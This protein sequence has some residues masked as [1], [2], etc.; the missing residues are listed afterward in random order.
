MA[1]RRAPTERKSPGTGTGKA[2]GASCSCR[3]GTSSTRGLSGTRSPPSNRTPPSSLRPTRGRR[4]RSAGARLR[5][6]LHAADAPPCSRP[7]I[8]HAALV[9]A[10][11]GVNAALLLI[12]NDPKRFDRLAVVAPYMQLEDEPEPPDPEWL[13]DLR[14]DWP[15]FIVPFMHRGLHGAGLGRLIAE[16]IAIGLEA[17]P[18]VAVIQELELDWNGRPVCSGGSPAQRSS[19]TARPTSRSPPRLPRASSQPCRTHS[20]S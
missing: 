3:R 8:E 4:Q 15:G 17:T 1:W 16:M 9:T 11:R 12:A 5:L 20:W 7:G 10:S 6:S 18:E 14:T 13:E 2:S 19:S